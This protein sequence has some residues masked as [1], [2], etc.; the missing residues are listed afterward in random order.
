[1][2]DP[3]RAERLTLGIDLGTPELALA[4]GLVYHLGWLLS[5]TIPMLVLALSVVVVG[6]RTPCQSAAAVNSS[7][8]VT[9]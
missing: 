5:L 4:A 1:V 2:R 9:G 3:A 7:F 6:H 8:N